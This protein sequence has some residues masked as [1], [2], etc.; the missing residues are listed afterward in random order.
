MACSR[1]LH[2]EP[3]NTSRRW[4]WPC[5]GSHRQQRPQQDVSLATTMTAMTAA[6]GI[7]RGYGWAL[8]ISSIITTSRTTTGT[9]GRT[10]SGGGHT[11]WDRRGIRANKTPII[12]AQG[13]SSSST[14][15]RARCAHVRTA[16][17]N[18]EQKVKIIRGL[19]YSKQLLS[20]LPRS[21]ERG[22]C[23]Q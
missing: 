18:R 7:G 19:V 3:S 11:G 21:G 1:R 13:L 22:A 5:T 6:V 17:M 12:S 4:V 14:S 15:W 10:T 16:S 8:P 20:P 9:A 2:Q 23:R